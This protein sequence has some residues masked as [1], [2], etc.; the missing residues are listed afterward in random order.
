MA[1]AL[2]KLALAVSYVRHPAGVT[3]IDCVFLAMGDEEVTFSNRILLLCRGR[4]GGCPP[5]EEIRC[6]RSLWIDYDLV[7]VGTVADGIFDEILRQ[8]RH[9]PGFFR[10]KP[11]WS[12]KEHQD[13]LLKSEERKEKIWGYILATAVGILGTLVVQYIAKHLGLKSP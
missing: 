8:R 7:Y 5:L 6:F 2:R 13:L 4:A 11:S 12:P 9:C 3:C 1:K 10:Y